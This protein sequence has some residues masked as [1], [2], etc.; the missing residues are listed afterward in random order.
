MAI[1][2]RHFHQRM[3][4]QHQ[5]LYNVNP[6]VLVNFHEHKINLSIWFKNSNLCGIVSLSIVIYI[7]TKINSQYHK[8]LIHF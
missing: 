7:E 2:A 4:P 5:K 3:N 8:P 1:K 6:P